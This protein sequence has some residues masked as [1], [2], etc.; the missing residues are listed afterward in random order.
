MDV[1]S[2]TRWDPRLAGLILAFIVVLLFVITPNSLLGFTAPYATFGAWTLSTVGVDM[3]S[4]PWVGKWFLGLYPLVALTL[5]ALVGAAVGAVAG[6]SFRIRIPRKKTAIRTDTPGGIM[7][8]LGAGVGL[9][10]NLGNF[11]VGLAERMDLAALLFTPGLI[12]GIYLGV[13]LSMKL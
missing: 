5:A 13:R 3:R 9:G 2:K 1:R 4:V 7:A 8:G 10:C 11:Y 12:V 6:K